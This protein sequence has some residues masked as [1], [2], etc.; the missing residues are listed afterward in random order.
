ME[1]LFYEGI[2]IDIFSSGKEY[3]GDPE[4]PDEPECPSCSAKKMGVVVSVNIVLI[5][6]GLIMHSLL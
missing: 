1:R 6:L 5:N 2:D 3:P 4:G